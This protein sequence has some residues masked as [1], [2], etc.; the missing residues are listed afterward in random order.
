MS[1]KYVNI[2]ILP[3]HWCSQYYLEFNVT[4]S[5][6]YLF[7]WKFEDLMFFSF[8]HGKKSGAPQR[9][10]APERARSASGAQ[11]VQTLDSFHRWEMF[12]WIKFIH[13]SR[14]LWHL[15]SFAKSTKYQSYYVIDAKKKDRVLHVYRLLK[16]KW[17]DIEIWPY[18]L[19]KKFYI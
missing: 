17:I 4:F 19:L 13:L 15:I 6:F 7:D 5:L 9:F 18:S 8:L 1:S 3:V 14:I 10:F 2:K 16:Y 12:S 11:F